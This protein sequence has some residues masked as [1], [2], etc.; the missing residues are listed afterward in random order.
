MPTPVQKDLEVSL[1]SIHLNVRGK[2]HEASK[3]FKGFELHTT[4]LKEE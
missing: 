2:V 3:R 4:I 1:S